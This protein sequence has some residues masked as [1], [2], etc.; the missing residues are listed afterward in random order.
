MLVTRLEYKYPVTTSTIPSD[1]RKY[2]VVS[3]VDREG[4]LGPRSL[5]RKPSVIT[6]NYRST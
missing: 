6:S 2:Q 4:G 3:R 5:A 1:E